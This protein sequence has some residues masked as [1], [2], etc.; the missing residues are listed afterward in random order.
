MPKKIKFE[1]FKNAF[2][3]ESAN[4]FYEDVNVNNKWLDFLNNLIFEYSKKNVLVKTEKNDI[5]LFNVDDFKFYTKYDDECFLKS[6]DNLIKKIDPI[7]KKNNL[8]MNK[9]VN[10]VKQSFDS[11][12]EIKN[13]RYH[14]EEI[15][16][17]NWADNES[18][19]DIDVVKTCEALTSPELRYISKS[20]GDI[21]NKTILDIGCGLGE[22]S[23]YF[24]IKGANVTSTDISSGMLDFTNKL[25]SR[26]NVDLKTHLSTA[27]D[28]NL[29]SSEKFDIIYSGNLM[30]HVDINKTLIN[31]KQ[32]LK[33]D[34]CLI[35]WD[36]M[37][38][39]PI[40][41]VYRKIAK[42]VR[43]E[44][45]HPFTLKDFNLYNNHFKSVKKKY[46]WFFT[47]VIFLIMSLIQR[48]NPIKKDFGKLL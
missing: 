18:V 10:E 9:I 34:G 2:L 37:A 23:V 28:L 39:N 15:F 42:N 35:T 45:E 31:I 24:A 19:F 21:K 16:H 11:S 27:E 6:A 4:V 33:P 43:T 17:D 26:Y 32:H 47:L 46:F 22:C 8:I 20:L 29:N 41:N 30:H 7:K 48:R 12:L 36:P 44:D 40:I 5:F 25:A 1:S 13:P 38:Y 14:R 3:I